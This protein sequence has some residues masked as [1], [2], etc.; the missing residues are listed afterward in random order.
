MGSSSVLFSS[1]CSHSVNIN[2]PLK[3][4]QHNGTGGAR[5]RVG[6]YH[7]APPMIHCFLLF[8]KRIFVQ[9]LKLICVNIKIYLSKLQNVF[10]QIDKYI[11][12]KCIFSQCLYE[13]ILFSVTWHNNIWDQLPSQAVWHEDTFS[14][15]APERVLDSRAFPCHFLSLSEKKP[16]RKR[17][18]KTDKHKT[19]F[20]DFA[21][22]HW[23]GP[24]LI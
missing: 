5:S 19:N 14:D 10:V 20:T 6:H 18:R 17:E 3:P 4:Y 7:A 1:W 15:S 22:E 9:I 12:P 2:C 24:R 8:V 21:P 23:T 13:F 11:W 16:W